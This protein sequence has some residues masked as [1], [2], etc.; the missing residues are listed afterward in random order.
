M[1]E[2]I[3]LQHNILLQ[4]MNSTF[5]R[6]LID[7]I[8]WN[9]RL[10]G[11][12]GAR[13]AGKTTLL[14]QRI[15]EQYGN[16]AK[17]LYATL[18][19]LTFNK[20]D[21]Y[22]LAEICW[23]QGVEAL[24]LDEVH[25]FDTWSQELKN[26]YDFFPKLK[27]VFTGSSMLHILKGNADLSRRAVM[28][29]LHGLSFR[30]FA[31]IESGKTFSK[32]SLKDL[33]SNHADMAAAIAKSIKPLALFKQYLK[34]GFYPYYLQGAEN[35]PQKL[36]GTVMQML[37]YDVPYLRHV[38]LRYVGKLKQL[39][40]TIAQSVPFK[41]NVVQL[42]DALGMSRQAVLLYLHHLQ[43][44]GLIKLLQ[45]GG[46]VYS[47]L[48]KPDKVYLY[49]PNLIHILEEEKPDVGNIRE[50]FFFQ[51][52]AVMHKVT[53]AAQGD[54]M[55]DKKYIFEVGGKNKTTTQIQGLKNAYLAL[56]DIEVGYNNRIPLWLFGWLY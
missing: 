4:Q 56:D 10:T 8:A 38:E 17:A 42:A 28:H 48:K 24:F 12:I 51:Q 14:L 34:Y 30:E 33:L 32:I 20:G 27:V 7:I 49:H 50:T 43:D 16:S 44:A 37:E 36:M 35:Y 26:V 40:H 11:I 6:P 25:K 2:Q 46:A 31:Q 19:S 21:L 29:T 5:R 18:D 13:G 41:P 3:R 39:M 22:Q 45:A 47:K 52:V 23:Q 9:E 15:K 54:F 55:V 53:S 1:T